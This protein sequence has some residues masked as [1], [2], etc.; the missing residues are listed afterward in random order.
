MA[1]VFEATFRVRLLDAN[2]AVARRPPGDGEL[3]HGV[4]GHV[5]GGPGVHGVQGRST[6]RSAS[7]T[8]PPR[9]APRRTSP[10]TRS[11]S[12]RAADARRSSGRAAA[13]PAGQADQGR[14][15]SPRTAGSIRS[16]TQ[17]RYCAADGWSPSD[18]TSAGSA[19]ASRRDDEDPVDERDPALGAQPGEDARCTRRSPPAAPRARRTPRPSA[20]RCSRASRRRGSGRGQAGRGSA[21]R[22]AATSSRNRGAGTPWTT[23]LTPTRSEANPSS[24][25]ARSRGSWSRRTSAAVEP[26]TAWFATRTRRGPAPG[27]SASRRPASWSGH[28]PAP[29]P[30]SRSCTSR[31]CATQRRTLEPSV[32]RTPRSSERGDG[33]HEHVREP[34]PVDRRARRPRSGRGPRRPGCPPP[35]GRG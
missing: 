13:K 16:T 26:L 24:G 3:R 15:S 9:T 34:L 10:S 21:S 27:G 17:R 6:G 32:T 18:A 31:R 28:R 12:R 4:L 30:R 1:N 22:I 11:G 8:G 25:S 35:S 20:S 5:Q 14:A 7:T 29:P 23:S 2:G 33:V 19:A